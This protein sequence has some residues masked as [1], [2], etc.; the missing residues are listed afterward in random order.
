MNPVVKKYQHIPPLRSLKA[1][2][3]SAR[4]MSF[5]K[6]AEELFVTQAAISHQIKALEELLG[7][8]LFERHNRSLS[9]TRDGKIYLQQVRDVLEK[10]EQA[11]R[12]LIQRNRSNAITISVL[13]SF[14]TKWLV[15][16]LWKFQQQHPDIDIRVSAYD[17]PVD[18]KTEEVD[19]A[20][21][22]GKGNWPGLFSEC[23]LQE[24]VFP[25]CSPQLAERFKSTSLNRML[26]TS[27]L[28]H[29]DYSSED[30]E[31]WLKAAGLEHIDTS[32]GTRFSHTMMMLEA[33][34]NAQGVALGRTPLVIDDIRRGVLVAPFETRI[35]SELAYYFVCPE[36]NQQLPKIQLLRQWLQEEAQETEKMARTVLENPAT[37][38]NKR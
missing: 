11:S 7:T 29:D 28:L 22:Y 27:N 1:L 14:A 25:V 2:E 32:R 16:R 10:L 33:A 15:K 24:E 38:D 21:R 34:E 26:A 6:A 12:T 18:F 30:W 20:I 31:M 37:N 8:P 35:S 36:G 23:L 19:I 9:L 17:W 4:H 13:P 3:A 5:T